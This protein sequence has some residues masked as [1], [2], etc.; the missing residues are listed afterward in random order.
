MTLHVTWICCG[1]CGLPGGEERPLVVGLHAYICE[2]C[3]RKILKEF[4]YELEDAPTPGPAQPL[5]FIA[6]PFAGLDQKKNVE[7]AKMVCRRIALETGAMPIAPHLHFP[8][9]LDDDV[10][11]ERDLGIAYCSALLKRADFALFALP[12]WREFLSVGMGVEW[13]EARNI[14]IPRTLTQGVDELNDAIAEI[15][16]RFPRRTE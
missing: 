16:R 2:A 4:G 13:D 5:V 1:E 9:F 8:S 15:A 3:A 7:F 10:P 11:H 14:D 6:S 12:A